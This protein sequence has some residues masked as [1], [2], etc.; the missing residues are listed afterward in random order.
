MYILKFRYRMGCVNT[1]RLISALLES[2]RNCLPL[3]HLKT[4]RAYQ[5]RLAFQELYDQLLGARVPHVRQ[6]C[7]VTSAGGDRQALGSGQRLRRFAQTLGRPKNARL[8]QPLP[9]LR[10]GLGEPQS[11]SACVS[12]DG[13]HPPHGQAA[14]PGLATRCSACQ[15]AACGPFTRFA[16]PG[17]P[18]R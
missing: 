10:Q 9:P 11:Q 5:I 1:S 17:R 2:V 6:S 18:P 14:M 12:A 8:A 7:T 13:F 4:A 3:R 15:R 16:G